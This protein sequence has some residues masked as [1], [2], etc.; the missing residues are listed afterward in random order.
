MFQVYIM[1]LSELDNDEAK[2]NLEGFC[3]QEIRCRKLE[4]FRMDTYC[5]VN[6]LKEILKMFYNVYVKRPLRRYFEKIKK[7]DYL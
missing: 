6:P 7:R 5:D 1:G 3:S 4:G 2:R